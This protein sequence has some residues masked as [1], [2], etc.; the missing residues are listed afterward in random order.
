MTKGGSSSIAVNVNFP[1]TRAWARELLT[2]I[3]LVLG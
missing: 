3:L 1:A 2:V